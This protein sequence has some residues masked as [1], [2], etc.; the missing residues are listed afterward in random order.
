[1]RHTPAVSS[2]AR[3][4]LYTWDDFIALPDDD[5][6]EL[7]DGELVEVEVPNLPHERAVVKLARALDAWVERAGGIVVASGFKI[8]VNER[9]GVMPDVQLYRAGNEPDADQYSGLVRGRPDLVVEV[10]SP[11]GRRY[12]RIVKLGY[13]KSLEVP[14]YWIVDPEARTLEQLFLSKEGY[15]I[16]RSYDG[17]AVVTSKKLPGLRLALRGV[18]MPARRR[19]QKRPKR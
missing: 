14:E 19:A 6:R 7:I 16:A 17:D 1:M 18:W 4:R 2:V 15:V 9:R 8:R 13:Y 12:D 11:S 5:R 3:K 10:L